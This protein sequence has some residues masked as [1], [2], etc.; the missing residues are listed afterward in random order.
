MPGSTTNYSWNLPTVGGDEDAWGG[1]LNNNW[2]DLDT[3]LGGTNAIEFAILDGAT[4]T[5]VELNL[6]DGV[7]WTLTDFNGLTSTVA[8]LNLLDGVTA[9]TGADNVLV[10]GTA[11]TDG[12]LAQ[13]NADGDAVGYT[14]P[15][16][17]TATWETGTDTTESLVSPA[18][19]KAAIETRILVATETSL[20]LFSPYVWT[21]RQVVQEHND[22]SGASVSSNVVTLP[23]GTYMM[24]AFV[25]SKTS[26]KAW[27]QGRIRDTTGDSDIAVSSPQRLIDGDADTGNNTCHMTGIVTLSTTSN[28]ELQSYVTKSIDSRPTDN[29]AT[30][31]S[32]GA[33][34]IVTKLA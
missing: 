11:G 29:F 18:K 33:N 1:Y 6:L 20:Y 30:G 4:V 3:L 16:Q 21:K 15:T 12:Q 9:L 31:T 27:L 8:E 13:W 24:Q 7:T 25:T 14:I 17:D 10:T 28:I 32:Q 22:I 2:S 5:T 19:L 23:A 34:L 26:N